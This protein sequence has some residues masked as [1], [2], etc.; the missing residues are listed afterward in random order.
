MIWTS[1]FLVVW[2]SFWSAQAGRSFPD[3]LSGWQDRWSWGSEVPEFTIAVSIGCL[4]I[5]GGDRLTDIPALWLIAMWFVFIGI[6]YAGKQSG[7][8]AY[9]NHEGYEKDDNGDGVVDELDGRQSTLREMNDAIAAM[10]SYKLG[11]EGYSWIWAASKGFITTVPIFGF[12]VV[13]QP[14]WRE[15]MSHAEGRLSGDSNMYMEIGD[16]LAYACSAIMYICFILF[17]T[18]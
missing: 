13:F 14:I 17:I 8:W 10:F 6:S 2:F 18:T 5:W 7:T 3:W 9:L 11:D 1:L 16:G 15:I 4:G 12:G